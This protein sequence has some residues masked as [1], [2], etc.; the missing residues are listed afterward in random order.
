MSAVKVLLKSEEIIIIPQGDGGGHFLDIEP[1]EVIPPDEEIVQET[2]LKALEVAL[3]NQTLNTPS[4][5]WKSP[6]LKHF[7]IRSYNKFMEGAKM[8]FV[9]E[10]Q[11]NLEI[12]RWKP[13]KDGKG[14]E[15]D[16][17]SL[18]QI[19]NPNKIGLEI[20]KLFGLE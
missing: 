20:L 16:F 12:E 4:K 13:A 18:K 2:I 14:F 6:V 15:Q 7:G 5:G 17:K 10:D 3:N 11:G 8:C 19:D 1:I 9:F